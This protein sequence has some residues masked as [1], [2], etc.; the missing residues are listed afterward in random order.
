[1]HSNCIDLALSVWVIAGV[2]VLSRPVAVHKLVEAISER[3]VDI[4]V[5]SSLG[6]EAGRLPE[7]RHVLSTVVIIEEVLRD[8]A[9]SEKSNAESLTASKET[10]PV[11]GVL[12]IAFVLEHLNEAVVAVSV[13]HPAIGKGP[14]RL[15]SHTN[16]IKG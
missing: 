2:T 9:D 11:G 8:P 10:V 16:S 5:N 15:H 7:L 12:G 6:L 1:M 13:W 4:V 14:H 3:L